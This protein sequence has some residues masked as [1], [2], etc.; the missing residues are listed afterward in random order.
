MKNGVN[1]S[2]WDE[3]LLTLK[4]T[5]QQGERGHRSLLSILRVVTRISPKDRFR[6]HKYISTTTTVGNTQSAD[7]I[8]GRA[9]N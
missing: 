3:K 6:F 7:E 5:H 1:Q 8:N 9:T 2:S 4:S